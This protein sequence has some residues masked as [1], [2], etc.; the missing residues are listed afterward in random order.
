[1]DKDF[2]TVLYKKYKNQ[3]LNLKRI[4]KISFNLYNSR[5]DN[6]NSLIKD[7]FFNKEDCQIIFDN[8]NEGRIGINKEYAYYTK[9]GQGSVYF[10]Y[11]IIDDD[12]KYEIALKFVNLPNF[13][14]GKNKYNYYYKKW[15]EIF[16][17][18]ECTKL[19]KDKVT[20]NLPIMYYNQIC[21]SKSD[22]SWITIYSELAD[23]NIIQWLNEEHSVEDWKSLFF[24]VWHALDVLQRKLKL[25]HNDMRLPNILFYNNN[26]KDTFKYV[27]GDNKYYLEKPKFI[28]LIW[29]YGSCET[30]MHPGKDYNNIKNKLESNKD[31]HFLHDM[32]NRL[33]VFA[34]MNRYTHTELEN[35]LS[36]TKKDEEY[37][38][39]TKEEN[40]KRFNKDRFVEKYKISLTYYII[41]TGR[42]E[43]LYQDRK[44]EVLEGFS[45]IYLPPKEIDNILKDLS[46][47]YNCS[48]KGAL[49]QQ[50]P[51]GSDC[52]KI[53]NPRVLIDKFL[54]EYKDLKEDITTSFY[55]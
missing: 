53:P 3:Y 5:V 40:M 27:I 38:K 45:K 7:N 44:E 29:D 28:F 35:I 23:G 50:G 15:R 24:Q 8:K 42:F 22:E 52:K 32:Y 1:M 46:E 6:Y 33:R 21:T 30:L 2:Y 34:I 12:R 26:S 19:V 41:E 11:L 51:Y 55:S 14:L 4:T 31:L 20:Q 10:L 47:N 9:G 48:Y 13:L 49:S 43:K 37:I 39:Q 17:L 54:P 25:V 18:N 16:A 36:K